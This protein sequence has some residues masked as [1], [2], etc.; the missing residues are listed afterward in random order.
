MIIIVFLF[1]GQFKDRLPAT[2]K[3]PTNSADGKR[4]QNIIK[5]V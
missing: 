4:F 3:K 5:T 2:D 1:Y